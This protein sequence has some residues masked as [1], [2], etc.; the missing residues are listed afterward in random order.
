VRGG[1]SEVVAMKITRP[2]TRAVFD[3]HS[4]ADMRDLTEAERRRDEHVESA[5]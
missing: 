1:A 3:H 5:I 2:K 4:I